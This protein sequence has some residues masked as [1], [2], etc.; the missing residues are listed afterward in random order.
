M[1]LRDART[2]LTG[3][4]L[5]AAIALA[6]CDE[7]ATT[8]PEEPAVRERVMEATP[9]TAGIDPYSYED[10]QDV[11]ERIRSL[12]K[13]FGGTVY[14]DGSFHRLD[15]SGS[16]IRLDSLDWED[17]PLAETPEVTRW[18]DFQLCAECGLVL[19]EVV[20][21]GD[22]DGP[23]LIEGAAPGVSWSELMGYVVTSPT[24]LQLFDDEGRF[25]RRIGRAGEGPGEFDGIADA[26]V[27]GGRLVVL[28]RVRRSWSIFDRSGRFVG[29]RPY[30]HQTGPFVPVGGDR[31]AVVARD[32]SSQA[33]GSPLHLAHIDSG[34]PSLHFGSRDVWEYG[35]RDRPYAD[36][37]R[38]SVVGRPGTVW[39]GA[40]GSPRVQEWS[41][42]DELLR[43]IEGE[44]PWFPEVTE[45]IDPATEPPSTL[46]RSIA[47]DGREYLWMMVR[48]ADPRWRDVELE[49]TA[50]GYRVPPERRA[51]Y[52]DTRL[53]I[54]DLEEKR[55]IGRYVWDSP[56]ARLINLGGEP[57]VSVVEYDE[58]IVPQVVVYRVGW[59]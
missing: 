32:R 58:E 8:A 3:P 55:H 6:G 52:L 40:A 4:P 51:D 59:E 41:V 7:N 23:G 49:R 2:W 24:F 9:R 20:R 37:I 30:G 25:V 15:P 17:L 36:S 16:P 27:V 19:T 57:A 56:Y 31:V 48:T 21:F 29:R 35:R 22:A 11:M 26:H 33:G 14:Y 18:N 53:D 38:G 54:F 44:L 5:L 34:V 43:V 12:H 42:D 28:D 46:L 13:Y 45:S 1:S 10:L 50:D 47:L 39:W